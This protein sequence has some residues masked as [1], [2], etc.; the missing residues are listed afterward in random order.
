MLQNILDV[1]IW[2]MEMAARLGQRFALILMD[3]R[4]TFYSNW[5]ISVTPPSPPSPPPLVMVIRVTGS[6]LN[7][8]ILFL[9]NFVYFSK[10]R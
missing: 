8:F 3:L 9:I 5:V 2:A 6:I 1:E 4:A 7:D 10:K